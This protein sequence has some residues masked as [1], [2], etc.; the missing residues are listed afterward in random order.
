M[1]VKYPSIIIHPIGIIYSPFIKS[2]ETPIQSVFSNATGNI[3][4]YPE[5]LDGLVDLDLFSHI[6]IIYHFNKADPPNSLF[7]KPYLDKVKRG[8]FASRF[9]S[10]PNRIGFSIV[11]LDKIENRTL[12]ISQIDVLNETP[13][14]DIKPYVPKFDI[15]KAN[16]GWLKDKIKS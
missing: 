1:N 10:R 16:D 4:I 3:V 14:L 8:I 9:P 13:L 6:I 7:A 2:D 15:H 11:K 5:Y 12:F